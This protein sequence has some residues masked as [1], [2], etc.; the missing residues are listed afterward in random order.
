MVTGS[1]EDI[2]ALNFWSARY[3]WF[4][5]SA[6]LEDGWPLAVAYREDWKQQEIF[7]S[8]YL[9]FSRRWLLTKWDTDNWEEPRYTVVLASLSKFKFHKCMPTRYSFEFLTL[10]QPSMFWKFSLLCIYILMK[11]RGVSCWSL[12][13]GFCFQ[14]HFNSAHSIYATIHMFTI[15]IRRL[16]RINNTEQL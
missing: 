12:R 8:L 3:S 9:W 4:F 15:Y 16:G 11:M 2:L 1:K 13:T 14:K 10:Q 5:T 6:F 7:S